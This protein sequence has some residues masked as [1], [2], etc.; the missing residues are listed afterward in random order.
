M[1]KLA[2]LLMVV[3]LFSGAAL[4]AEENATEAKKVEKKDVT[5]AKGDNV[6][7]SGR[8][9]TARVPGQGPVD[10]QDRYRQMLARR[11]EIHQQAIDELL[12][13]KKIAEE[14]GATRTVEAIQKIIDKKNAEYKEGVEQFT[15]Q[16]RERAE[17]IRQRGE[18]SGV[19]EPVMEKAK[20]AA[21][22]REP[23]E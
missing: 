16:Q 8:S 18:K 19:K 14:E 17:Q 11:G 15:R 9:S 12:E 10:R 4:S 23:V 2:V 1:K 7:R 22:Q 21:S 20:E 13:I 6:L 3:G 5:P